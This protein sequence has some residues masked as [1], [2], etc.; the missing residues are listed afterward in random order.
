[1]LA[2]TDH[3]IVDAKGAFLEPET[4]DNTIKYGR[5]ELDEG[6]IKD[7]EKLIV[8]H[9]GV[10][11]A[12]AAVFRKDALELDQLFPEVVGAYDYWISILLS[13][14]GSLWYCSERLTC[15]RVHDHMETNR[16]S[17][18]KLD[19]MVFIYQKIA[20]LKLFPAYHNIV[21]KRAHYYLY[22]SGLARLESGKRAE[23]ISQI[24]QSFTYGLS[25]KS[26]VALLLCYLPLR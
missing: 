5:S 14:K 11:L 25:A 2:F 21:K 1:V 13:Q 26:V 15:Y 10:P 6:D 12:M 19:N 23:A 8:L 7:A 24:K 4:K 16:K 18:D 17:A 22:K 3:D 9:N 20:E